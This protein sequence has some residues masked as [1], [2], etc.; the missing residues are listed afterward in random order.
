MVVMS[1]K[2]DIYPAV[3]GPSTWS[4]GLPVKSSGVAHDKPVVR[5]EASP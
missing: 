5:H 4:G 2:R 1:H 3:I